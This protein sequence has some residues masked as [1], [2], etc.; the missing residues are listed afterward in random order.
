MGMESNNDRRSF[1]ITHKVSKVA[2]HDI[3]H[4]LTSPI[5][6]GVY[7]TSL[8]AAVL[9]GNHPPHHPSMKETFAG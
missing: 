6:A 3:T 1:A 9:M 5:T 2:P 8:S 4:D 7:R